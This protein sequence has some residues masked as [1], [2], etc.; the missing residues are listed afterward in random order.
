MRS[1]VTAVDTAILALPADAARSTTHDTTVAVAWS[2][3]SV[4]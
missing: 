2:A 3:V 1:S 4:S